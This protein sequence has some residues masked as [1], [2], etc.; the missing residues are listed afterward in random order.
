MVY[1]YLHST[2]FWEQ[3]TKPDLGSESNPANKMTKLRFCTISFTWIVH[4]NNQFPLPLAWG[5]LF[6][7][8]FYDQSNLS[9][10]IMRYM[11]AC[12]SLKLV[13]MY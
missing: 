4:N 7:M 13:L 6:Y 12:I 1:R 10:Y 9:S 3:L 5:I 11:F 2:N 8:S